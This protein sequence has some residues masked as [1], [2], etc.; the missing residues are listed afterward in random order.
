MQNEA[1]MSHFLKNKILVPSE[2]S[3]G[4]KF[5]G[6]KSRFLTA[7]E[8]DFLISDPFDVEIFRV[9]PAEISTIK[10]GEI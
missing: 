6:E 9:L 4:T 1:E 3:G 7:F 10:S 5:H 2:I 8:P